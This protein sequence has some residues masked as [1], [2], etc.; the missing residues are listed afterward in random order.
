MA[1]GGKRFLSPFPFS[2]PGAFTFNVVNGVTGWL[3][4]PNGEV[5]AAMQRIGEISPAACRQWA[6]NFSLD[7]VAEQYDEFI[8]RIEAVE[9]G[10]KRP[11]WGLDWRTVIWPHDRLAE[12]LASVSP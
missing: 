9:W 1:S 10:E 3:V 6:M 12:S 5:K 8:A 7:R 11:R 4:S 2:S